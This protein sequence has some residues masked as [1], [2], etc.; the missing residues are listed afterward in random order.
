MNQKYLTSS[1]NQYIHFFTSCLRCTYFS[2]CNHPG[3]SSIDAEQHL[4]TKCSPDKNRLLYLH[5]V[6]SKN[7]VCVITCVFHSAIRL[8]TP[9]QT[10]SKHVDLKTREAALSWQGFLFGLVRTS[11]RKLRPPEVAAGN[12]QSF[13]YLSSVTGSFKSS[14]DHEPTPA[15]HASKHANSSSLF[16]FI[17]IES[18]LLPCNFLHCM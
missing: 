10:P 7:Q 6:D 3:T 12:P 1:Y 16:F 5:N 9:P 17:L 11:G 8:T 18:A 15:T 14:V 2:K 4:Q 13:Q